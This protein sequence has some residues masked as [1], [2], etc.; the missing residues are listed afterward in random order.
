MK[1]AFKRTTAAIMAA[2]ILATTATTVTVFATETTG[3]TENGSPANGNTN[4]EGTGAGATV[5]ATKLPEAVNG[6]ITLQNDVTISYSDWVALKLTEAGTNVTIDLNGNTLTY[7]DI[8]TVEVDNG[9]NLTIKNGTLK[10]KNFPQGDKALIS[11]ASSSSVTVENATIDTTASAL[12]PYGDAASVTVKDSTIKAGVYAVAT[13]AGTVDNYNVVITLKDSNFSTPYGWKS[14]DAIYKNDSATVTINVP[15]TLNVD[16]CT[17]SGTRQA[18]FVRAGTA[19]IENSIINYTGAY[20]GN[21]YESSDWGGGNEVPV[22]AIVV[23]NRHNNGAYK[24]SNCTLTNTTVNAQGKRAIYYYSNEFTDDTSNTYDAKLTINSGTITGEIVA[25]PRDGEG[26][27]TATGFKV[28]GGI[29]VTSTSV[30]EYTATGYEA[31]GVVDKNNTPAYLVGEDGITT[32]GTATNPTAR[33]TGGTFNFDPSDYVESG[34]VASQ[35]NGKYVVSKYVAPAA[36]STPADT[37]KTETTTDPSTGTT[38]TTT[39]TTKADGSTTEEKI[40]TTTDGTKTETKTETKADGSSTSSSTVTDVTGNV[41]EK[42]E[43]KVEVKEDKSTTETTT[44]T[45]PQEETKVE[46]TVEKDAKGEVTK[47]TTTTSSTNAEDLSKVIVEKENTENSKGA[48]VAQT[49]TTVINR[50]GATESVTE[51]QVIENIGNKTDAVVTV[52]KNGSGEVQNAEAVVEKTGATKGAAV[53][54]TITNKVV[55]QIVE[56]AGEDAADVMSITINVTDEQGN[57]KYTVT[58]DKEAL[59][60]GANLTIYKKN[61]D[62][63]LVMVNDRDYKVSEN[64][65]VKLVIKSSNDFV[66][67]SEEQNKAEEARIKATIA[68][69]N[70]KKTIK[71]NRT[72]TMALQNTLNMANVQKIDYKSSKPSVAHI[73]ANGK[74]RGKKSG[75]VTIKAIITLKNGSKKTVSMKLTVA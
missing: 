40:E 71:K 9:A 51:E 54:A 62:G 13:N 48:D 47:E 73:N 18:V 4:N 60:P 33:I 16:N 50:A 53:Q 28:T 38:T 56:A 17:I 27:L 63:E 39:T 3:T 66:L 29:F 61:K 67:L 75:T 70:S 7:T 37:S 59:E 49:T 26:N 35:S 32:S 41:V 46:T 6:V 57:D 2:M 72:T 65:N 31:A 12:F 21:L 8:N 52:E 55:S 19:K 1:K 69:K 44:T 5:S 22:A 36:P 45:K 23:G 14:N 74:I 68:A 34:Y 30:G 42:S 43:T 24:N 11:V 25:G 58:V 20:G 64:G 15:G 10:A